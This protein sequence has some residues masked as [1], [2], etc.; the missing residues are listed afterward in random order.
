[1]TLKEIR[2]LSA[3]DMAVLSQCYSQIRQL[4]PSLTE[5]KS[6]E[7]RSIFKLSANRL[8]FVEKA[9]SRMKSSPSLL[10]NYVSPND[11]IKAL[12]LYT[13]LVEAEMELKK[14]LAKVE[15]S[16]HQAGNQA[17]MIAKLFYH[18]N[19]NAAK[20]GFKEAKDISS[21]LS[22]LYVAGR[23]AKNKKQSTK[24]M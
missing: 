6:T 8:P 24:E 23:G 16:K 19:V 15:N 17:L 22:S 5:L 12:H 18:Q 2:L 1:M 21:E 9:I 3:S 20:L 4:I 7:K 14:L 11:A 13:Q 10:P